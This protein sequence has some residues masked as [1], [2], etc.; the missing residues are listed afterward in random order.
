MILTENYTYLGRTGRLPSQGGYGYYVLLYAKA[1][2]EGTLGAQRL[3][4]LL[5]MACDTYSSFYN[6]QSAGYVRMGARSVLEWNI[7]PK[8][9]RAWEQGTLEAGDYTYPRWVDMGEGD[10]LLETGF[11]EA[12]TETITWGYQVLDSYEGAWFPL[13]HQLV[14]GSGE[15]TLPALPGATVPQ[16]PESA[17]LGSELTVTLNPVDP[18]FTHSLSWRFGQRSGT[19]GAG[20]TG[21]VTWTPPLDLADQIPSAPSGILTLECQ[22]FSGDTQVGAN[23]APVT[24]RVPE[25]LAP[26]VTATWSD[27]TGAAESAGNPVQLV[28]KIGLDAQVVTHHGAQVKTTALTLDGKPYGSEAL[29]RSGTQVLQLAVTDSRGLTG[30]W[31]TELTVQ[32]YHLPQ[33]RLDASRW[34][35]ADDSG[36]ADDMGEFA[37]VTLSGTLADL[38]GSAGEVEL[39]AEN[40]ALSDFSSV[41]KRAVS[42]EFTEHFYI[43]APSAES[44]RLRA[45]A[46]DGYGETA[47]A[48]TLSIGFATVDF[49]EGGRGVAFGTTATKEG[50]SCHMDT[51]FGGHRVTGLPEPTDDTD[52]VSKGYVDALAGKNITYDDALEVTEPYKTF[53]HCLFSGPVTITADYVKM[54]NC[55]F[56]ANVV[57]NGKF[58]QLKNVLIEGKDGGY[59]SGDALAINGIDCIVSDAT[60]RRATGSGINYNT[61]GG[62]ISHFQINLCRK[63]GMYIR[64]GGAQITN[65][66]IWGCGVWDGS[67]SWAGGFLA[68]KTDYIIPELTVTNVSIQQNAPFGMHLYRVINSRLDVVV[69]ANANNI[70]T[71]E[72][73]NGVFQSL[74]Y[75]QNYGMALYNCR[76]VSGTVNGASCHDYWNGADKGYFDSIPSNNHLSVVWES[77]CWNRADSTSYRKFARFLPELHVENFDGVRPSRQYTEADCTDTSPLDL[78]LASSFQP[79]GRPTVGGGCRKLIRLEQKDV[80]SARGLVRL[81]IEAEG[82]N[83]FPYLKMVNTAGTTV[84]DEISVDTDLTRSRTCKSIYSGLLGY[85]ADGVDVSTIKGFYLDIEFNN[86]N[87]EALSGTLT[88]KIRVGYQPY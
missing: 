47:A 67:S 60:I 1:V 54:T 26:T 6:W 41:E 61:S 75:K 39:F 18:S 33:I 80:V 24:L 30:Y 36:E 76:N 88:P 73:E 35:A 22:T 45:V 16:V 21:T 27:T 69:L 43:S 29:E 84:W 12:L 62:S 83:I 4:V 20:L 7:T 32:A 78:S 55:T 48:M 71:E 9:D 53:D 85:N 87:A 77:C 25:S 49:L 58:A 2:P 5:R 51:D 38:P 13:D 8:P 15:V 66:K 37:K 59:I 19:L 74:K 63:Y 86:P 65:G 17:Y 40:R 3:S 68:L 34:T 72:D 31:R 46:R 23:T 50:F 82:L 44:L 64:D 81:Y 28:S 57:V 70:C 11:G 42:G 56:H 79:G 52:A 10:L 14:T